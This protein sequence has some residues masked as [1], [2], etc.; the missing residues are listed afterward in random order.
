MKN[1]TE[2]TDIIKIEKNKI[3]NLE[4]ELKREFSLIE[5]ISNEMAQLD[6]DILNIDYPSSGTFSM[7]QQ[8]NFAMHNMKGDIQ[9]LSEQRTQSGQR[10]NQIRTDMKN[11]NIELEKFRFIEDEILKERRIAILKEE[12]K[13]L[14]EIAT[15][16]YSTNRSSKS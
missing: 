3:Q 1:K 12:S 4:K 8:Y 11:I 9:K 6:S 7:L 5:R 10:V 2:F 14:D 13:E 16:L 15:I